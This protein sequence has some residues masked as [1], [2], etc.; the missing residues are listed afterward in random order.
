MKPIRVV[1]HYSS[2]R[3]DTGSPRA[4]LQMVE[5]LD[6]SRFSP[7]FIADGEGEL[8]DA[9]RQRAVEILKSA[10]NNLSWRNPVSL[11]AAV[12][13]KLKLLKAADAGILHMNEPGWNSDIVLAARLANIPV[14][15]HLHNPCEITNN[16]LNFR[17]AGK[18]FICSTAQSEAIRN[19][20][21]IKGKCTVLHNAVDLELFASGRPIREAIGLNA[22]DVV[23]GTIAQIRHGKG[24]DIF[25]GAAEQLLRA[26]SGLKFVI[27]GPEAADEHEYFQTMMARLEQAPLK[28]NV[29]YLG[30]RRDIPNLL[31]SFD[32]FCLATRAETFG[33]VVIEAMAAGVPVVASAVGGVPEIITAPGLGRTVNTLT[34]AAFANALD[35]VL[36]IGAKRSTLGERGRKSLKGRFDLAHMGD[37]LGSVYL[38]LVFGA[39][40]K[41][42]R[43]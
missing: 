15:L 41:S 35:D 31:K 6:R 36:R 1:Y 3:L 21:R 8:V 40:M 11:I 33:I 32:V 7:V 19:F 30:S 24:I 39:S 13:E 37:T 23:I 25:L 12:R 38:D 10:V 5:S 14:V 17:I 27:V 4:L 2:V 16:N 22:D 18:I 20:E 29:I 28:D 42:E 34:S 43:T 9:M 26:R